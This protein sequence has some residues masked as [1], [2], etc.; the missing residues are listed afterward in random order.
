MRS[1]S[2]HAI[3]LK[4]VYF[5]NFSEMMTVDCK[6]D[7]Q[8]QQSRALAQCPQKELPIL[9][10]LLAE[11]PQADAGSKKRH[12]ALKVQLNMCF[13]GFV[14]LQECPHPLIIDFGRINLSHYF[15]IS[16]A[17]C[18]EVHTRNYIRCTVGIA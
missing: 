4:D 12:E 17:Q 10:S 6:C 1:L 11:N 18:F 16:V 14:F 9:E 5:T 13:R 7:G 2:Y 15:F 3:N 8:R